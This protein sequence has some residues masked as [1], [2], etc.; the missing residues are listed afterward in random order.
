MSFF[1]LCKVTARISWKTTAL[2]SQFLQTKNDC[3]IGDFKNIWVHTLNM[4]YT[5]NTAWK[6]VTN[7]IK[8]HL[9]HMFGDIEYFSALS[10]IV[11]YAF[12]LCITTLISFTLF[13]VLFIM[14]TADIMEAHVNK[15]EYFGYLYKYQFYHSF[16][17]HTSSDTKQIILMI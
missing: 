13:I 10:V 17:Q 12:I 4:T 14:I 6:I 8:S 3:V 2:T 7:H 5:K 11:A 1:W 16:L 9:Q 15:T